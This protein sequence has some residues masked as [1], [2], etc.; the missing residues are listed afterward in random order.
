MDKL[1]MWQLL[2]DSTQ[3]PNNPRSDEL[4]WVQQFYN[5]VVEPSFKSTLPEQCQILRDKIFSHSVFS[6]EERSDE[7]AGTT[8]A[9]RVKK[10]PRT[11]STASTASRARSLSVS[12]AEERRTLARSGS[13]GAGAGKRML[14]REVSMSRVFKDRERSAPPKEA[15]S[16][17]RTKPNEEEE[18]KRKK[19]AQARAKAGKTLVKATPAKSTGRI[20]IEPGLGIGE[21]SDDEDHHGVGRML[22]AATPTKQRIR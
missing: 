17:L 10:R 11:G 1:A 18:R 5:Q 16:A 12:L 14:S 9:I 15:T 7:E 6:D 4:D 19:A 22:V 2:P 13:I 20:G 8:P 21:E 3:L